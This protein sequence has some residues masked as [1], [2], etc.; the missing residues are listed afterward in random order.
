MPGRRLFIAVPLSS[1]V[2]EDVA[3]LVERVRASIGAAP[4]QAPGQAPG[5]PAREVRWVR[6]D[7]L[8]LTLRFLGPTLDE[9]IP[10]LVEAVR[11]AAA[12]AAPF[13]VR[14]AGAGAFP[15]A[16]RPRVLWLDVTEGADRLGDLARSLEDRLTAAGWPRDERP[17]RAHLTLARSDG[18][19]AGPAT[20][21]ALIAASEGFAAEWTA[22]RLVLFESHTG[23][24]PARYEALSEAGLVG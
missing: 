17:F 22:D 15:G 2:C 11:G 3:G 16:G 13:R 20:A 24:G 18:V 19:A 8:H 9:R 5:G 1:G 14:L 23:G 10:A 12:G 4:G 6:M 7:G 21:R